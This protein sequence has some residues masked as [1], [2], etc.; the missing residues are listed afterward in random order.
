MEPVGVRSRV[1]TSRAGVLA[2]VVIGAQLLW[3]GVLLGHGFFSQ[4]DFLVMSGVQDGSLFSALDIDYA[5]G[6]SPGGTLIAWATVAIAPL[7]W[8]LAAATVLALQAAA[9]A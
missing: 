7:A 8:P 2:L 5:G 3:R 4:D 6:F 1:W 9:T